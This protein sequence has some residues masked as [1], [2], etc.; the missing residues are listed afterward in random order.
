[1]RRREAAQAATHHRHPH[2]LSLLLS[3]FRTY[4]S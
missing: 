2:H 3:Q 4:A 1:V